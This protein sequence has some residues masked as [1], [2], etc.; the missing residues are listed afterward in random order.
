[1]IAAT[2]P[3]P[4]TLPVEIERLIYE[5][6]RVLPVKS[7]QKSPPLIDD[8]PHAA[9][10]DLQIVDT[11]ARQWP[12]CNWA[13]CC[14]GESCIWILDVDG[15][16]GLGTI[17]AWE[18]KGFALPATRTVLTSQGGKQFHF[19]YPEGLEIRPSVRKLGA[20]LDVRGEA[21]Y[22]MLP[23]SIHPS[24]WRY[25]FADDDQNP[26]LA[27]PE[28]LLALLRNIAD[29]PA[30]VKQMLPQW[31]TIPKGR[32]NDTLARLGGHLRRKGLAQTEIESELQAANSRRCR[33][34]LPESEVATIAASIARYPAGGPDPLETAWRAIQGTDTHSDYGRFLALATA[35]Q[36]AREG[37][38][39]ALP[40]I[41]LAKLFGVGFTSVAY[42]RKVAVARG[43]LKP[44]AH[45][46]PHRRANCYRVDL[47]AAS[48]ALGKNK[49]FVTKTV[50]TVT[51]GLV[52]KSDNSPIV[53]KSEFPIV[54]KTGTPVVTKTG[55]P[56]VTKP[57]DAS[58][59]PAFSDAQTV[60]FLDY[61]R[62]KV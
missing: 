19:K 34:P 46:I 27:A 50:T 43:L 39:I 48:Q 22:G 32:R 25:Q 16:V 60:T 35:L 10:F 21:S 12:A 15:D 55:F 28:W 54:T 41:R 42:W 61:E 57:T 13:V 29:A 51:I 58:Q 52:T 44:T 14:G 47:E 62:G 8:W 45:Y 56:I 6:C 33:P 9:S 2:Q 26:L 23:P 36:K 5:G 53:T 49:D 7:G 1:M 20:G 11:W 24:G 37:Q 4:D 59:V 3:A 40:L 31:N 30:A 18:A 17:T 38:E